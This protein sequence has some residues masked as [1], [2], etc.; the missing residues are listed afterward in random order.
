MIIKTKNYLRKEKRFRKKNYPLHETEK[1]IRRLIE[2]DRQV[3][4]KQHRDH[5]LHVGG[6]ELHVTGP[7]DN[8]LIRYSR[9]ENKL[10]L[11]DML[12]HDNLQ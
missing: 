7:R 4:R 1:V 9:K 2:N 6:R 12:T 3:L 5:K 11:I 8:W 10:L